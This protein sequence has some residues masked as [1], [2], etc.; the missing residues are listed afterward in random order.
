MPCSSLLYSPAARNPSTCPSEP[1]RRTNTLTF[2]AVEQINGLRWLG[3]VLDLGRGDS[4]SGRIMF[5][6]LRLLLPRREMVAATVAVQAAAA[7]GWA[8]KKTM[9]LFF[10]FTNGKVYIHINPNRGRPAVRCAGSYY[11][12]CNDE[13]TPLKNLDDRNSSVPSGARSDCRLYLMISEVPTRTVSSGY[14]VTASD[15]GEVAGMITFWSRSVTADGNRS[16]ERK[17]QNGV[18]ALKSSSE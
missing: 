1:R 9:T 18:L 11:Q 12:G 6:V 3:G 14:K 5:A 15:G 10:L 13:S 17:R 4:A 8:D 2:G 16:S 7:F